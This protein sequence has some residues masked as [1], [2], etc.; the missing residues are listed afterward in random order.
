MD[1]T[2]RS[3]REFLSTTGM[4]FAALLAESGLVA[5]TGNRSRP[6]IPQN[7][8]PAWLTELLDHLDSEEPMQ[9]MR[10]FAPDATIRFAGS[11]AMPMEHGLAHITR[12]NAQF[13][14][15][16]HDMESAWANTSECIMAGTVWFRDLSGPVYSSPFMGTVTC[17]AQR[18]VTNLTLIWDRG[19]V[20]DD[21]HIRFST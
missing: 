5:C 21:Y 12:F 17:T 9:A 6:L 7:S 1:G 20:P 19:I 16:G 13:K 18:K 15:C 11:P 2:N 4:G 3:R 10:F 8:I 14:A